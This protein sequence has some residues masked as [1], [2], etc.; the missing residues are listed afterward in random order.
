MLLCEC[1]DVLLLL[2]LLQGP[3]PL[4]AQLMDAS[5]PG[6]NQQ[7][8]GLW[9]AA[10]EQQMLQQQQQRQQ[11][12][13]SHLQ[14]QQ[15]QQLGLQGRAGSGWGLQGG[16]GAAADAA[17]GGY[18]LG[19][20]PSAGGAGGLSFGNN[21]QQQ[22]QQQQQQMLGM[23]GGNGGGGAAA[24]V[25]SDGGGMGMEEQLSPRSMQDAVA[26]AGMEVRMI[27]LWQCTC[28]AAPCCSGTDRVSV[29]TYVCF[30]CVSCVCKLCCTVS[31]CC[32]HSRAVE[33]GGCGQSS[34]RS[35]HL[36]ISL[37]CSFETLLFSDGMHMCALCSALY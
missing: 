6:S 21:M 17:G 14:Q 35:V 5:Q 24:G 37:T 34:W 2:L 27:Q 12:P 13:F 36:R 25:G 32:R 4:V 7:Q 16:P 20:P 29:R 22:Q 11:Q 1:A 18:G 26:Q 10:D 23:R 19:P 28:V 3:G 33:C 31:V 30:C 8:Q 15:Q 9:N